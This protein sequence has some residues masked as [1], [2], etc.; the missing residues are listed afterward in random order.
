MSNR[1]KFF[2]DIIS[3]AFLLSIF[4]MGIFAIQPVKKV[5]AAAPTATSAVIEN[6]TQDSV[7]IE[8]IGAN[9][10]H[11]ADSGTK[12]ASPAD[13]AFIIYNGANPISATIDNSTT[14][15]ATFSESMDHS[16]VASAFYVSPAVS[17][18][19]SWS[20][21]T[22]TFDHVFTATL[23]RNV[24]GIHVCNNDDDVSFI[25]CCFNAVLA[26][27]NTD[28]LTIDGQSTIDQA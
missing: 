24:A 12:E 23:T 18:D 11:F 10:G 26:M 17:G 9:F 6:S 14:I 19:F 5:Y 3:K 28:T 7:D 25:E 13:L 8:I 15:T 2:S 22:I 4:L 20:G 1:K 27:E 21:D 16:S